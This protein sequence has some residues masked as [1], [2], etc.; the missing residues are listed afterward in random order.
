MS[1]SNY[2]ENSLLDHLLGQGSRSFAQ[3]EL[4]VALFTGPASS[5][6]AALE[7]SLSNDDDST[8][9]WGHWEVNAGNYVRQPVTFN[10]SSGGSA[11]S[12]GEIQFPVASV[13]YNNAA[14]SGS[15]VTYL[16]VV[17][18]STADDGSTDTQVLVYGALTNSKE[19]LAG[20]QLTVAAGSLTVSLS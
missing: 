12:A 18:G 9:A 5:V 1:A 7:A 8:L 2:T 16:A 15:S 13:N 3:P 20:D 19:I 17:S 4:F 11:S 14:T 6:S 10:A